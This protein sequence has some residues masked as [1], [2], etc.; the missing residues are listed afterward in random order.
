MFTDIEGFTETTE[1]LGDAEAHRLLMTHDVIVR[2]R[3]A[4]HNGRELK[5]LGDGFL[6]V[7]PSVVKALSCAAAIQADL[8]DHNEQHGDQLNVR[9]GI[10]AGGVISRRGDVHGRNVILASRIAELA[11]GGEVLVSSVVRAIAESSGRFKFDEGR[12]ARLPG[13]AEDHLV[14]ALL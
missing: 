9:I 5:T 2:S 12:T 4:A 8:C 7:F 6:V 11:K 1:R 14:H 3:L 10:H 13:L